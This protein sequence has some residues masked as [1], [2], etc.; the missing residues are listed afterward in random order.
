[1]AT[2]MYIIIPNI[3]LS[4]VNMVFIKLRILKVFLV[5]VKLPLVQMATCGIRGKNCMIELIH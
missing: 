4:M 3:L 1:M 2:V 5:M